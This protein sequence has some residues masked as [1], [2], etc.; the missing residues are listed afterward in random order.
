MKSI[1]ILITTI[2]GSLSFSCY[3]VKNR[4]NVYTQYMY[5]SAAQTRM[6]RNLPVPHHIVAQLNRRDKKE[7]QQHNYVYYYLRELKRLLP[8]Q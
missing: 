4:N 8:Q 1:I 5:R 3:A 7:A 6:N 2:I